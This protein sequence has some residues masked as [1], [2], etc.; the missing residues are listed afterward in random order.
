MAEVYRCVKSCDLDKSSQQIAL[1]CIKSC[2]FSLTRCDLEDF[3]GVR[4][5]NGP[6]VLLSV[7]VAIALVPVTALFAGLTI[8]LLG[9]DVVSLN[10]SCKGPTASKHLSLS[11]HQCILRLAMCLRVDIE[12]RKTSNKALLQILEHAG[13][14]KERE[15][16]K[17]IIPSKPPCLSIS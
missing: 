12:M 13:E 5:S 17:K 10:V 16:A 15:Y 8:G 6:G 3:E 4:D 14:P 11:F 7:S 2:I 9:L 1:N